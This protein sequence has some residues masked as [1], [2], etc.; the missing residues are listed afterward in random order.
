MRLSTN[1]Q[2]TN[3]SHRKVTTGPKRDIHDI[4][5]SAADEDCQ[6]VVCRRDS[7]DASDGL[8]FGVVVEDVG[9][10][11]GTWFLERFLALAVL[12]DVNATPAGLVRWVD[13]VM[14]VVVQADESDWGVVEASS[15]HG[16]AGPGMVAGVCALAACTG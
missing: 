16:T 4:R 12:G 6:I 15:R 2:R 3:C 7:D 10:V 8:L 11:F 5:Q 14:G 1:F 9:D 13:V